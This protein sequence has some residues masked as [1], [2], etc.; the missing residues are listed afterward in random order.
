[1]SKKFVLES[2]GIEVE[3]GI[4]EQNGL[5][6]NRRFFCF[7]KQKRPYIILKWAQTKNGYI[8]PV[9]RSRLQI[10]SPDS[11]KLVHKWRTEEAAIMVGTTT[12]INDNPQL[13]ARLWEGKQ[14]LRIALDRNLQIPATH[15]LYDSAAATWIINEQKELIHGNV[16]SVRLPFNDVLLPSLLNKLHESKI[17]SVIVEGGAALLSSFINMGLWDEARIF[18]GTV[19]INNGIKAPTLNNEVHAFEN[20]IGDD[21]LNVFI[22]RHSEYPYVKGMEL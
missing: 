15:H 18:T 19:S 8:A 20:P 13:T 7:H 21:T 9:D 12:A 6:L 10:T 1:M 22:N 17:L 4:L 16:H 2:A 11:N 14:P 3:T 5:W